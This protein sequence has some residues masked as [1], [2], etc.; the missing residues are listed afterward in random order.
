VVCV[1]VSVCVYVC[2]VCGCE[3]VSVCECFDVINVKAHL[4][5]KNNMNPRESLQPVDKCLSIT[6]IEQ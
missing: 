6:D 4:M 3:C 1:G 5:E 2:C